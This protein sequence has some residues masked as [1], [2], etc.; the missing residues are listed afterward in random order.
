MNLTKVAYRLASN[1]ESVEVASKAATELA[2]Q[3]GFGEEDCG[4]ID[5]VVRE[6]TVNAILHGNQYDPAKK[7][8]FSLES[9]PGQI[10]ISVRDEGCGLDT[11][12]VP[13]PLEEENLSK[14]SGRGLLLI[15][16]FMD[17]VKVTNHSPGMEITMTKFLHPPGSLDR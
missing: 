14:S 9:A 1:L 6:A 8:T 16:T 15:R 13:D 5:L 3:C 7:V 10:T 2:A 4:T 17:S 12:A 11:A